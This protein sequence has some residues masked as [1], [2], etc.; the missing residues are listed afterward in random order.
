MVDTNKSP[1]YDDYDASKKYTQLLAVPGRA[2]QAREF[3]QVQ[4]LL[5]DFMKRLGNT[6]YG[7]GN[8]VSGMSLTV[9]DNVATV[10]DGLV[11]LNGLIHIFSK[12]SINITG[13]GMEEIC[14]KLEQ[15]IVTEVQDP[16]L[17]EPAE[18][19]DNYGEEGAH[20]IKSDPKLALNDP[21]SPVVY[22]LMDGQLYV[23]T[24]RP[25]SDALAETLARRTYD[26]SGNYRV[27]GLTLWSEER[28]E[29]EINL[30]IEAGKAYVKGFE[31][32]K[33]TSSR[34]IIPKSL[35]TR[36]VQNEPR[37]Y[38]QDVTTYEISNYPVKTVTG[39][40]GTVEVVEEQ[41]NQRQ[42]TGR[43]GLY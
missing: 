37:I 1:Y 16:S 32:I 20:R 33:P 2:E 21:T 40:E 8:I 14:I 3:T 24:V 31:I 22:K 35:S 26:E 29:E 42:C 39:L 41:K 12:Q 36:T 27:S 17:R 34:V 28:N 13:Q 5:L 38:S 43:Q 23:D 10:S 7:E 30:N 9:K 6:Q 18:G 11:Y 15:S 19:F 4:T 25:Q